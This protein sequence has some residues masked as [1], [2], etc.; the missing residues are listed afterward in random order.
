MSS[1]LDNAY[2]LVLYYS[3]NGHVKMLADQIAQGIES[4]GLEARLRTV[5]AVSADT[6]SKLPLSLRMVIS[7]A[8]RRIWLIVVVFCLEARPDSE[9]W[10]PYLSTFSMV[11][12]TFG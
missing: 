4:E 2:I 6:E 3:R 7:I 9:T 5:P 1:P 11:L 10:P 12:A 8:P